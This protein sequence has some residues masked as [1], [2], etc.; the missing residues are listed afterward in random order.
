MTTIDF[1]KL[2]HWEH[3]PNARDFWNKDI[4]I[5]RYAIGKNCQSLDINMISPLDGIVDDYSKSSTWNNIP[6]VHS[7]Q[8]PKNSFVVNC[9]T[10]VSPV[11]V[12][13]VF[14]NRE[15]CL[16]SLNSIINESEGALKLP[17]FSQ[18]MWHLVEHEADK[19][20][21]IYCSL[22]DNESKH[23]FLD[24]IAYRLY[25]QPSAMK[26]YKNRISEQYFE[27][28][29]DFENDVFVDAGGFDGDTTE[30]F[31]VRYPNY[32][33]IY[34]IEPSSKNMDNA[35]RRLKNF[36]R[37][38]F[39]Q[40]AVSNKYQELA[41]DEDSGSASNVSDLGSIKVIAEPI[42][43]LIKEKVTFLKMDLEGWEAQALE[44]SANIIKQNKPKL[45]IAVY[46]SSKDYISLYDYIMNIN[47]DYNVYMRH[48]TE[49]W[50]ETI[51]FFRH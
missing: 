14:S 36:S 41:F 42:D 32:K 44:G 4:R 16:L 17:L 51:M 47:P 3:C 50:S 11:S 46:H 34:L 43:D 25:L 45:A 6:I 15:W 7:S 21:K 40:R 18:D 29:M 48:Y 49:G 26:N 24:T 20:N 12:E 19:L 2:G 5:P 27:S 39:I 13:N 37:I 1:H 31:A 8:V 10:S 23:V 28:F 22:A 30:G 9:S 33:K 38:E 35:K